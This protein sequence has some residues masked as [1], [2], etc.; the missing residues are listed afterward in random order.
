M[1]E[2]MCQNA[3]FSGQR[4]ILVDTIKHFVIKS[5]RIMFARVFVRVQGLSVRRLRIWRCPLA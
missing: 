5:W 2:F 4:S 1:M 3:T